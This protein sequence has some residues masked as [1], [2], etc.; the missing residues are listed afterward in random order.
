M[1]ENG[2]FTNNLKKIG[3]KAVRTTKRLLRNP[4]SRWVIITAAC[5]FLII[6]L[7]GAAYESLMDSFSKL[8]S[9]YTKD[10]KVQYNINDNSIEISDETIDGLIK[11]I[12][13]MGIKLDNL[14]LDREDI[15]KIYAAEVVS[16]EINRGVQETEGKYYGRVFV[17]KQNSSGT[18]EMLSYEPLDGFEKMSETEILNHFSIEDDK[19]CIA[20][21]DS[22]IDENG[23]E[24][25]TPI[26][27]K[28]NY[29]D[30]ISQYMVPIE[31]L[32]DLCLISQNS[33]FVLELADKIINETEIVIEVLQE[34]TVTSINKTNIYKEETETSTKTK[35]YNSE[36]KYISTSIN[37]QDPTITGPHTSTETQTQTTIRSSLKIHSVKNWIV[38]E[39]HTY[40]KTT[41]TSTDEEGPFE[42]DDE[43]KGTHSY[44]NETR[45]DLEDGGYNLNSTSTIKRKI[46]QTQTVK[47][48]M[49]SDSYQEGV[50][51]GVKD[52]VDEFIGMLKKSYPQKKSGPRRQPI[53]NL[54]NGAE[55]LFQMLLNG[56]RTQNLE[57]IM[58]YILGKATGNNYGVSDFDFSIF[59]SHD[60]T[61][62][63]LLG[64]TISNYIKSWEDGSLWNYE[65]GKTAT[66][67]NIVTQ[68]G[69]DYCVVY[70]DGSGGHNNFAYGIATFLSNSKKDET[71]PKFGKGYYNWETECG[72]YG[73][74]VRTLNTGDLIKKDDAFAIYALILQKFED[75]V[76]SYLQSK[77][78]TLE[79]N[80]R[81]ALVAVKYQY[82]NLGNFAEVYSQ[83]GNTEELRNAFTVN[84]AHPFAQGDNRK[85]ANWRV[86]LEGKYIARDGTEIKAG[87]LGIADTIHKYMEA[88]NYKYCVYGSNSGEEHING[89]GCGLNRT[90]EESKTGYQN[91]CCAT[92][93]SWVLQEAGYIEPSEHTNGAHAMNKLLQSKGWQII[94][95]INELEPGDILYYSSGH[96]EIYA[97]EGKV[98]NAGSGS[99]IRNASPAGN[100]LKSVTH[101]LRAPN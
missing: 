95:N 41:N 81:D 70:E 63:G 52:K 26:I 74:N 13:N 42:I 39:E 25:R 1:S 77:G 57:P 35:K 45:E 44:K 96:V 60:F 22:T 99:A 8:V 7:C 87:I 101:G 94:N 48:E 11:V 47:T 50:S 2:N 37:T 9:E 32:L 98:Y 66:A 46:E 6:A 71:H 4:V 86:F 97:G 24:V 72:Q 33:G 58:R 84:G 89:V 28:I 90:F 34:Q 61:S 36:G 40:N 29:K 43:E 14:E 31:F 93:V 80:E 3:K 55:M 82:G 64:S 53:D 51:E 75:G 68:N 88:N 62:I 59:A 17:K 85:E 30:N 69:E 12:E 54:K 18:L 21:I 83:Y 27:N 67:K 76:D 15:K 38:E 5:V 92:Y 78:I 65:M 16:S 73:V 23:N 91:S 20:S 79:K 10:N 19:I 56:G 100:G 49:T